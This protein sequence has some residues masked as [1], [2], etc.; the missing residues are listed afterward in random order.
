MGGENLSSKN[1]DLEALKRSYSQAHAQLH[2][3]VV[4]IQNHLQVTNGEVQTSR[5]A[6][7]RVEK[8][9]KDRFASI[10]SSMRALEDELTVGNAENRKQMLQ[11]HEEISR[12]HESLASV[13]TEFL[14]HKR[15]T[16]AVHN[17]LQTHISNLE[18][19]QK[20][21]HEPTFSSYA[22]LPSDQPEVSRAPQH[23]PVSA[24]M[25]PIAAG[26]F[27]QLH[28]ATQ[29]NLQPALVVPGPVMHQGG[30]G[31]YPQPG[32]IAAPPTVP[33]SMMTPGIATRSSL[34]A[35]GPGP[36]HAPLMYR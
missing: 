21:T 30:S 22:Q 20:R 29:P 12:I 33:T 5:A 8:E 1:A 15:A 14:D 13:Q 25:E 18:V 23:M 11:L 26:N 3:T 9:T 2:S 35:A 34:V 10:D 36:T 17:K 27:T 7:D 4:G 16:N 31:L 19:G 6:I 28:P 32:G 24:P